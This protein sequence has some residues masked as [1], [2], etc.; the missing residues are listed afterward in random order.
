MTDSQSPFRTLVIGAGTAGQGHIL[1]LRSA[2]AEI[3]GLSSRTPAAT[4]R[5]AQELG[6]PRA[7]TDW[8]G[9]LEEL[10]PD[11]CVV[12]TPGGTHYE[13]ITAALRRGCHVL[14]EKP[15]AT[16]AEQAR[17][18][19]ELARSLGRKTA[20]AACYGYQPQALFARQLL[21]T[22]T[23][24]P[25]LEVE[26]VSH[27]GW[28]SLMSFGWMHQL[29]A[30]GGRLHNHFPNILALLQFTLSATFLSVQGECRNDL[31]RAPLGLRPSQVRRLQKTGVSDERAATMNW[32][33]VDSDWS[34]TALLALESPYAPAGRPVS[35]TVRHSALRTAWPHDYVAFYGERGTLHV[36]GPYLQ[37][38]PIL[39]T[40]GPTWEELAIPLDILD[41]L[42]QE[43]DNTLRNWMQLARDFLHTIRTGQEQ[44]TYPT[45]DDAARYQALIAAVRE[46]PGSVAP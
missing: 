1:A 7:S 10:R 11:V 19:A 14:S 32:E 29:A 24:G 41:R 37:G 12:A 21:A 46:S 28:P 5:V 23:I 17:E 3:V 2:G 38:S 13:M 43:T 26:C 36:Q 42:P 30:G 34:Y 6:I 25:L 8:R 9:L 44:G 15:L 16:T 40:G 31:R 22:E 4:E 33:A 45:F 39:Y 27:F 20:F 35:V 18:L